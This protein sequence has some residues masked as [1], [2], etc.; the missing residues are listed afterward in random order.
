MPNSQTQSAAN[1]RDCRQEAEMSK[2]AKQKYTILY[3]RLS[4]EDSRADDSLSIQN[5][6][7]FLENYAEQNG[8]KPYRHL[9]DDG[10]SGTQWARPGWQQLIAEIEAGRVSAVV[11]VNLDRVGRDY[12]RVGLFMEQLRDSGVR[13]ICVSDG[14]DTAN[15]IEDD[16]T[17]FRAILAEWYAKDCSKKIRTIFNSRMSQGYHCTGSIPYGYIHNPDNR[18][19]W[20]LDDTAAA[21]VR[22]IFQL[23][24]DGKGVYQI[25]NILSA[26]KILIPSAHLREQGLTRRGTITLTPITGAAALWVQFFNAASTQG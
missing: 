21:T 25:A 6:R 1:A 23:V 16:F 17:P 5:Q 11:T 26:D 3:E 18:Q 2:S 13:L 14:I 4:R 7:D 9:Q 19:E 15:G 10:Y 12:L 24:I 20:L 22:R 8:L